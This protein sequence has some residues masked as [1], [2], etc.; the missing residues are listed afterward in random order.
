MPMPESTDRLCVRGPGRPP[1]SRLLRQVINAY[2]AGEV[3]SVGD[4]LTT[5]SRNN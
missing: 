1:G 2:L 4:V 3:V 5:L